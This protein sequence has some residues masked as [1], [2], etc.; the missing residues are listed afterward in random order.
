VS[1]GEIHSLFDYS[2]LSILLRFRHKVFLH[3]QEYSP[4]IRPW[5]ILKEINTDAFSQEVAFAIRNPRTP[6]IALG[7]S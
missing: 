2:T 6:K 5:N 7:G 4:L 1:K 3:K